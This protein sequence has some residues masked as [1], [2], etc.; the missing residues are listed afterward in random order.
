M[1]SIEGVSPAKI[2]KIEQNMSDNEEDNLTYEEIREKRMK[3]NMAMFEWVVTILVLSIH[4]YI[5]C[6]EWK[7]SI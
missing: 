1:V 7:Y 6:F 3:E 2:A 5:K 4:M